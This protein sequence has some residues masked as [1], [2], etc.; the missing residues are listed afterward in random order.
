MGLISLLV[1]GFIIYLVFKYVRN[2]AN[3]IHQASKQNGQQRTNGFNTRSAQQ[4]TGKPESH[5]RIIKDDEGEYVDFEEV[6]KND[7]QPQ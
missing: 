2:I 1:F 6:E 5:N 3:V 4:A 7:S